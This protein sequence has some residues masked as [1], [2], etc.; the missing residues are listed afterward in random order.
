MKRTDSAG[1]TI[2]NK[3]TNG[4]PNLAI[5]ATVVDASWLNAVQEEIALLIEA[6]GLTLNPADDTQLQ[7]A[8]AILLGTGGSQTDFA[9]ANATG[10]ADVTGLV[11]DKATVKAVRVLFDL[12]RE[13]STQ[14]FDEIGELW[15]THDS[16]TDTWRIAWT[17]HN[18]DAGVIFTITGTGQVQYTSSNLSGGSYA[19]TLRFLDVKTIK[20]TA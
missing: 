10:P 19:G 13:T 15:L 3:Y 1:S 14:D 5:P 18:E 17:S 11:F 7:Q 9:I 2:D 8:L 12:H 20:Q 4:D 6:A 16:V